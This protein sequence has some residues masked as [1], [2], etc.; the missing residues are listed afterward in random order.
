MENAI[1]ENSDLLTTIIQII[2]QLSN[3]LLSSIDKN[4]FPLLDKLVFIDTDILA[5][6]DKM[7]K[8][9]ST[10]PTSGVRLLANCLFT[11]FV[12]YYASKLMLSHLT[13]FPYR[14]ST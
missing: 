7:N 14:I 13:R 10:S 9:I 11:A 5:T 3:N 8:I 4:I 6:G 1:I 2:N 12:L